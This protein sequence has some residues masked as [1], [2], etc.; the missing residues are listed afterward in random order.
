MTLTHGQA[1]IDKLA[2]RRSRLVQ[3]GAWTMGLYAVVDVEENDRLVL[4]KV[5]RQAG[6]RECAGRSP[7]RR[8]RPPRPR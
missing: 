8:R 7:E 2:I 1:K 6:T 4:L 5:P 3:A